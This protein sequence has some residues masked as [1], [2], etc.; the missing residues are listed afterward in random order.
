MRSSRFVHAPIPTFVP[1]LVPLCV[2][3]VGCATADDAPPDAAGAAIGDAPPS[4]IPRDPAGVFDVTSTFDMPVREA[5]RPLLAFVQGATRGADDPMRYV[6]DR[7]V[8]ELPDGSPRTIAELTV[9]FVAAYLDERLAE[10]APRFAPGLHAI[11]DGI[12]RV[13][14]HV[15]LA[16]SFVVDK[17]GAAVRTVRGARFDIAPL[18]PVLAF[19]DHGIADVAAATRFA[20]DREGALAIERHTIELRHGALVR[21]GLDRAVIPTVEPR[22]TDLGTALAVLVDCDRV[23]ELV[24]DTLGIGAPALFGTACDAGM[25]ALAD[26]VYGQIAALDEVPLVLELTGSAD[27]FDVDRN[28]TLDELRSGQWRGTLAAP[29]VGARRR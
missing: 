17:S 3:L 7:L 24:A 4:T 10:V 11:A 14:T 22:A 19:A 16:E 21:L 28:G 20:L 15:E 25:A 18:A 5:A 29:F 8:A 23:G 26:E 13:A 6:L 9:P 12:T 27:G 1:A 2:A